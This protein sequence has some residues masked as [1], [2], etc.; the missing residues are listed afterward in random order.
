MSESEEIEASAPSQDPRSRQLRVLFLAVFLDLVGFGMIL[1][2]LP[3]YAKEYG[4]SAFQIGLLF[5]S[6]SLAQLVSSPLWGRLSDRFGRRRILLIAILGAC[7]SYLLFAA[8][9]TLALL[10]IA[11]TA[12][13]AAAAN[14]TI[15]QAYVAD[16]TAPANR[17]KAM[18]WMGAAFGLGFI[19]GPALGGWLSH[20]GA[21]A[22][23]L[24]AAAL[25]LINFVFAA[26]WLPESLP[27]DARLQPSTRPL[28]ALVAL[29]QLRSH[30][31]LLSLMGL[32]FL[33]I[34]S[35]AA[36]E[37][38]LAL[39]SEE[40]LG[41]GVAETSWLFVFIGVVMVVV[42]GGLV[43]R[44][45]HRFGERTLIPV[46]IG[47]MALGLLLTT[48]VHST[49]WLLMTTALLAIGYGIHNPALMSLT[50]QR[51]SNDSQGGTLGLTRSFGTLG[52]VLGPLWGGWSFQHLGPA[53]PYWTAGGLMA[54]T[55][56]AAV[57]LM[58]R[59]SVGRS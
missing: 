8:A 43:G 30:H 56:L 28:F 12:A 45:V 29:P 23:P 40:R 20:W 3:F 15:A 46:G 16:V 14:Y 44:L 25:S 24:G 39:F 18:G 1:P 11:R 48:A 27:P 52:R 32:F 58:S 31:Q 50:S 53:W 10:F 13:G 17:A 6:Y 9:H 55:A 26:A 36:M 54:T 42:Q 19:F 47:I 22:V 33:V 38:T 2:L 21:V 49:A 37:S 7:G 4:A 57:L 35:F 34:F 51:A 59:L 5:A 41:F